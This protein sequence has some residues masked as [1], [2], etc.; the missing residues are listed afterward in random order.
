[1]KNEVLKFIEDNRLIE[2]NDRVLIAFSGGPDSLCLMEL[3]YDLR[4]TLEIEIQAAHINHNLRGKNSD[5]DQNFV[6]EYCRE[7]NIKLHIIS[8]DVE[9]EAS[10]QGR[11]IEE[12]ARNIRYDFFERVAKEY[13][14]NKIALAHNKN[15]QAETVLQRL[16]R[17]TGLRG[18]SGIRPMRDGKYIRPLLSTQRK[19]IEEYL[20]DRGM[21]GRID[22]SNLE[23]DY[24]RNKVRLEVLPYIK[25][26]F[27]EDIISSLY[28]LSETAALEDEFIS[29]S[30]NSFFEKHVSMRNGNL[31]IGKGLFLEQPAMINR[32]IML[33]LENQ[34]GKTT[35]FEKKHVEDIFLLSKKQSGKRIDITNKIIA[36]NSYGNIIL[37]TRE[38]DLINNSEDENPKFNDKAE[39]KIGLMELENS[40]ASFIFNGYEVWLE[41]RKNEG[42]KT[43]DGSSIDCAGI[44]E[45]T[46]RN[47]R[48]GDFI[49][50]LG[51]EKRKKLKKFFIDR[52]IEKEV[53]DKLPLLTINE[54]EV[55]YIPDGI[56]N[57]DVRIKKTTD[58][59]LYINIKK[60]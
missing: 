10:I 58:K 36:I 13:S 50:P 39:I 8:P 55:I 56:I 44:N 28:S 26:N 12:T 6:E 59:I 53:R 52:K 47:R 42:I 31:F 4:E 16:F 21:T 41:V 34:S 37:T 45:I 32:V 35:N 11:G 24:S 60:R 51:M 9:K 54:N 33:A 2:K 57:E 29:L 27:N 7:R 5:L 23:T 20:L 14:L 3:L 38:R 30:A 49:K 1:M 25:K 48:E 40:P 18:L 19:D 22:E 17:G 46:L 43:N 15:D